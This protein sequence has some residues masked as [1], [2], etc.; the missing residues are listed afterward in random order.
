MRLEPGLPRPTAPGL[1]DLGA[2]ARAVVLR[3]IEAV[4]DDPAECKARIMLARQCG[5][6]SDDEAA[7]M[8]QAKGLE[9]A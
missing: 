9:G 5:M 6:L 7:G 4:S 3:G 2:F 1:F 8:I